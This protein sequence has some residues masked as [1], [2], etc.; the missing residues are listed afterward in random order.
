MQLSMKWHLLHQLKI[1]N[2]RNN[3]WRHLITQPNIQIAR[4]YITHIGL[5]IRSEFRFL[6]NIWIN[7]RL[8]VTKP[9]TG[10]NSVSAVYFWDFQVLKAS[11]I[12]CKTYWCFNTVQKEHTQFLYEPTTEKRNHTKKWWKYTANKLWETA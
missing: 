2:I 1:L 8:L 5:E 4:G 10:H 9:K 12:F 11:T 7:S 3:I 6:R